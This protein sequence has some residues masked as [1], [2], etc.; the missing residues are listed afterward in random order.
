MAMWK[1]KRGWWRMA[2]WVRC[3]QCATVQLLWACR[4]GW[5]KGPTAIQHKLSWNRD[6]R[7]PAHGRASRR[8]KRKCVDGGSRSMCLKFKSQIKACLG[9]SLG[10]RVYHLWKVVVVLGVVVVLEKGCQCRGGDDNGANGF[11]CQSMNEDMGTV[12][13]W[14]CVVGFA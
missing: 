2:K 8:A 1:K 6:D 13:Q 9:L 12:Y 4:H 7:I 10:F 3:E 5:R 11:W 14:L